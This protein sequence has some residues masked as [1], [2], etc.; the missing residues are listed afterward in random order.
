MGTILSLPQ[1]YV[2]LGFA[3]TPS[4]TGSS[5][6]MFQD[7]IIFIFG[8]GAKATDDYVSRLCERYLNLTSNRKM[9]G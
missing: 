5:A 7:R 3:T 8:S 1:K 4:G 2:D 6:L 9:T